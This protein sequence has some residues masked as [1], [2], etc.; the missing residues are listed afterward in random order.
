MSYNLDLLLFSAN[1]VFIV[2]NL[3]GWLLKRFFV[4]AAYKENFGELY[5]AQRSMAML[6]FL[7]IFELPYLLMI[8]RPEALFYVDGTALL[9]F[10]SFM[11]VLVNAYFF[12]V[13]FKS[14]KLFFFMFPVL[15]CWVI[16]L[17]PVLGIIEFSTMYQRIMTIVVLLVSARYIYLLNQFRIQLIRHV[18]EIDEDEYSNEVDFPVKFAKSI[19]WF[20]LVICLMLLANFLINQ[21][22]GKLVRDIVFTVMNVS[23]LIYTLNPHRMIGN[24]LPKALK[25]KQ[26]EETEK[27]RLTDEQCKEMETRLLSLIR[28]EKLYLEDHLAMSDLT[29]RMYTNKTYLSEVIARSEYVSFYKLVNTLRVEHACQLLAADPSLKLEQVA[30]SSGFTSGSAFSQVFKRLKGVSPSEWINS[31]PLDKNTRHTLSFLL[32]LWTVLAPMTAVAS[33]DIPYSNNFEGQNSLS[34]WHREDGQC[35][36]HTDANHTPDGSRCLEIGCS[37]CTYHSIVLPEFA[38]STNTLRMTFWL[39]P[40]DYADN[41]QGSFAV[42]YLTGNGFTA[43]ATYSYNEWGGNTFVQKTIDF[44]VAGVTNSARIVIRQYCDAGRYWYLDDVTVRAIPSCDYPTELEVGQVTL[45][46]A[47]MRWTPGKTGSVWQICLNNDETQLIEATETPYILTGLTPCTAYT[48]KVRT[49]CSASE[50]SEWTDAVAFSTAQLTVHEG[51]E[52]S[53]FVPFYGAHAEQDQRDQ[54]LYPATEL[55]MM[56]DLDLTALTFYYSSMGELGNGVGNWTVSLGETQATVLD[57]LDDTTPLTQVFSGDLDA[58]FNTV[59]QT[60]TIPFTTFYTYHGGNLLVEF[61]HDGAGS[62]YKAYWFYGET[63][64]G[65]SYSFGVQKDFLP[66]TTFTFG[67]PPACL[68]PIGLVNTLCPGTGLNVTLSWTE[69]G[70]ATDWVLQYGTDANFVGATTVNVSNHPSKDLTCLTDGATYYARVKSVCGAGSESQWSQVY[71]FRPKSITVHEGTVVNQNVPFCGLNAD[72]EQQNQMIYAATELAEMN[73]A[74]I[75]Q[76]T[77]Y[78]SSVGDDGSGVGNWT[79]SLGE[80]QATTLNGLDV[81]TPMVQVFSGNL[82]A[83]FNTTDQTLTLAFDDYYLYHG[84]NLLVEF[85]HTGASSY[86]EYAFYGETVFGASYSNDHQQDF[87]PKTTFTYDTPPSCPRPTGLTGTLSPGQGIQVTFSWTEQ[88]SATQ[89]VLQYGM[90]ANF[91]GYTEE[92]VSGTPNFTVSELVIGETYYARVKSVCGAGDESAWSKVCTIVPNTLTV[93]EGDHYSEFIPVNGADSDGEGTYSECIFPSSM[94]TEMRNKE[95]TSLSFYLKNSAGCLWNSTFTVYM[96]EVDNQ[97]AFDLT[98]P[99][100]C[101]VVYTGTLDGTGTQMNIQLDEGFSYG[102]KNLLIGTWVSTPGE[103]WAS[104]SFYG[105]D[106]DFNASI[107]SYVYS[108]D[109]SIV[110]RDFLPKTTFTYKY[111]SC[112]K[113]VNFSVTYVPGDNT[114]AT[115]SW[116]EAGSADEW[117]V[118]YSPTTDFAGCTPIRVTGNPSL[119]LTGLTPE[120]T[121]YARVRAVCGADEESAWST[122]LVFS[123][124]DF[125][126]LTVCKGYDENGDIPV[127]GDG[128]DIPGNIS[129]FIIPTDQLTQM[130]G[131]E[132]TALR[133]YLEDPAEKPWNDVSFKV[134]MK[135]VNFLEMNEDHIM[136]PDNCTLVYTGVLDS[137]KETMDVLFDNDFPFEGNQAGLLIGTYVASASDDDYSAKFFGL[138]TPYDASIFK[139]GSYNDSQDF[140]PKTT[141]TYLSASS[142]TCPRPKQLAATNTPGDD[143]KEKLQWTQTGVPTS[144]VVEYGTAA[145]FAGA[146]SVAVTGNPSVLL[147]NLTPEVTYY[148]RVKA[149]NGNTTSAWSNPVSFVTSY[150]A[151]IGSGQDGDLTLPTDNYSKYSLTQQIYTAQ[152]IG[153]SGAIL[154]ID[155]YKINDKDCVRN[156]DIYMVHTNKTGFE[157]KHDWIHVTAGDLVFSGSVDFA[158]GDWTTVVLDAPFIYNGTDNLAIVIDDNTG[159]YVGDTRFLAFPCSNNQNQALAIADD[160]TN[161]N[162]YTISSD[163]TLKSVKNQIRLLVEDNYTQFTTA[164]SWDNSA[165]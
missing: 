134:Y 17:L 40:A 116:V 148:A 90:Y 5:P 100:L 93:C 135:E 107:Y 144:W 19:K 141:F 112:P 123:L 126:T 62:S 80:T 108:N 121:Y 113:P 58:L 147:T 65:A 38:A 67:N 29:Q 152:E 15:V 89:W 156:M 45:N 43:L 68:R 81:T 103:N 48:A 146:T 114:K 47:V 137:S 56:E 83:L 162:P 117:M 79:V 153:I 139:S 115:L 129:E 44:D 159:F 92:E 120:A 32:L 78:Y 20:P 85:S 136:G 111:V 124:T 91:A 145:D 97:R 74:E 57:G 106:P 142:P 63:V 102:N 119:S 22:I 11:L 101:T 33:F 128:V 130:R 131:K 71:A 27:H 54:M 9:F 41:G 151:I 51:I 132:I 55:D 4:P 109:T 8:G 138:D 64:F 13:F 140:L 2:T 155:F 42:G 10:S 28:D 69:R 143:T 49:Y 96:T 118:Q 36:V 18:R 160:D 76:M 1:L 122:I 84:G 37:D 149:V 165:N 73:G 21:P 77:F 30:L 75:T 7:Q 105:N 125:Q 158:Y 164:G 98:G 94:L 87:L 59:N 60:L 12:Q 70:S 95:I 50:Q 14:R 39:R 16:L 133:F 3:Y 6:Y 24:V 88:G 52:T 161:Y 61:S 86:K 72:S 82:D 26:I 25:Q 31:N 66:K 157:N 127:N 99:E 23:F 53:G 34:D 110:T 104:A 163:G 46:S 35:F 154:S 150:L